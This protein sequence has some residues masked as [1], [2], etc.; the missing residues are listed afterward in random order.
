[1]SYRY[2]HKGN[3][4]AFSEKKDKAD[5][6]SGRKALVAICTLLEI[7]SSYQSIASSTGNNNRKNPGHKKL[8]TYNTWKKITDR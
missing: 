8:V 5:L 1:M 3:Y 2:L 7:P 6:S 4:Q